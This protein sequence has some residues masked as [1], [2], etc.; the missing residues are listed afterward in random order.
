MAMGF[1]EIVV[2]PVDGELNMVSES[3][4]RKPAAKA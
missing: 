3:L 4:G 2:C 1:F